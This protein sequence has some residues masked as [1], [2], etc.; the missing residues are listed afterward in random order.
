MGAKGGGAW[1]LCL[2]EM[3]AWLGGYKETGR[4]QV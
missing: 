4:M 3:R 2:Y 1:G